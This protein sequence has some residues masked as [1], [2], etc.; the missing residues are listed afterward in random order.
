[1]VVDSDPDEVIS[2]RATKKMTRSLKAKDWTDD[3]AWPEAFGGKVAI[4]SVDED[5]QTRKMGKV[6]IKDARSMDMFDSVTFDRNITSLAQG[7]TT[8]VIW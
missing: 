3:V 7:M 1:M 6:A 8:D 5:F 4:L 2:A